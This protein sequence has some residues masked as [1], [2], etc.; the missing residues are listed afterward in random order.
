MGVQFSHCKASWSYSG[1]NEFRRRL[2]AVI[3][4]DLWAMSGFNLEWDCHVRG[5]IGAPKAISWDGFTDP[6]IPL[7]NHSD[8]EGELSHE[9][10]KAIAP[11]LREIIKHWPTHDY[12]TQMALQLAE[13]ME[14]AV[15]L[16]QALEFH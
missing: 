14:S 11:R 10:C 13:G 12:D 6:I 7:L 8:C 2:A 3:G 1:F 4:I 9:D 5:Q 15:K 16:G